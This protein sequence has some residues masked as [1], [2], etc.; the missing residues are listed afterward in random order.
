MFELFSAICN[1]LCF[2]NYKETSYKCVAPVQSIEDVGGRHR[3]ARRLLHFFGARQCAIIMIVTQM[4][5]LVTRTI[6]IHA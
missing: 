1:E 6:V 5:I 2:D 3:D 4:T